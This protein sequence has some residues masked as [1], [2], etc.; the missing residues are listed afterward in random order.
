MC[1][2]ST[3]V[4]PAAR[5]NLGPGWLLWLFYPHH[6]NYHVEHHMYPAIPHYNLPQCHRE[7]MRRGILDRAEV[8]P[9]GQTLRRIFDEPRK[10]SVQA[11]A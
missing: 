3:S 5:T 9:V 6:V 1:A 11:P 10:E 2:S 7:M 8:L 4:M